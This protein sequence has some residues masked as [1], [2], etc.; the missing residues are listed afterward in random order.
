MPEHF[1]LDIEEYKREGR[2]QLLI[3][4]RHIAPEPD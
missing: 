3:H 2:V 4:V 1:L